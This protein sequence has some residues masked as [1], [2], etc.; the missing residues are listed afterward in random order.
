MKDIRKLKVLYVASSQNILRCRAELKIQ[1]KVL[2]GKATSL[3]P[4]HT[5]T[6]FW[7]RHLYA[8]FYLP[9]LPIPKR[10]NSLLYKNSVN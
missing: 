8:E 3:Q 2:I 5:Q 6:L 7:Y 10:K 9:L 1:I 4:L